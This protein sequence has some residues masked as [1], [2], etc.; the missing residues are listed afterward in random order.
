[1][2]TVFGNYLI[3][4][5]TPSSSRTI[6]GLVVKYFSAMWVVLE[7]SSSVWKVIFDLDF[8][9]TFIHHNYGYLM[10]IIWVKLSQIKFRIMFRDLSSKLLETLYIYFLS[11]NCPVIS[12]PLT[13]PTIGCIGW[14]KVQ[15]GRKWCFKCFSQDK[16]TAIDKAQREER[17][18]RNHPCN[19]GRWKMEEISCTRHWRSCRNSSSQK[20]DPLFKLSHRLSLL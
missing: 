3:T 14:R 2:L 7:R 16:V 20:S 9:L 13:N 19:E 15:N 10:R 18:T 5:G 6:I 1:M 4:I 17:A 8:V 12:P 11:V